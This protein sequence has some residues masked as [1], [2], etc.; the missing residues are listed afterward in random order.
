[1][2]ILE[3]IPGFGPTKARG[4]LELLASSITASLDN[5]DVLSARVKLPYRTAI[6][7]RSVVR[8]TSENGQITEWR[9]NN[10]TADEFGQAYAD[11]TG[12]PPIHD[13]T[14]AGIIREVQNGRVIT[15]FAGEHQLSTWL[16]TRLLSNIPAPLNQWLDPTLGTLDSDPV[17]QL[18]WSQWTYLQ[19]VRALQGTTFEIA[20][21]RQPSGLYRLCF[22]HTRGSTAPVT[23]VARGR[24]L[25]AR[26]SSS[27]DQDVASVIIP[28]G[29]APSEDWGPATIAENVWKVTA[30]AAGGWVSLADP[31][32]VS[33]GPIAIDDQF[34]GGSLGWVTGTTRYSAAIV[35]ARK[36]DGAV[37]LASTAN[38]SVGALTTIYADLVGNPLI[39]VTNPALV[40]SDVG[41]VEQAVTVSGG[42]GERNFITNPEMRTDASG[43]AM[44]DHGVTV[45]RAKMGQT[46]APLANGS[47]PAATATTTPLTVDGLTPNVDVLY[48]GDRID[49]NGVTMFVTTDAIPGPNGAIALALSTGLPGAL[50]DN[51]PLTFTRRR[52]RTFTVVGTQNILG[53]GVLVTG[54][55][56]QWASTQ[57]LPRDGNARGFV[58]KYAGLT[59]FGTAMNPLTAVSDGSG[60]R[61][62][63]QGANTN[64]FSMPA[65]SPLAGGSLNSVLTGTNGT[66]TIGGAFAMVWSV[67]AAQ[68]AIVA[69]MTV[70]TTY[71][72]ISGWAF[73][74][75]SKV[76]NGDGSFT[77]TWRFDTA[78]LLPGE[79]APTAAYQVTGYYSNWTYTWSNAQYSNGSTLEV[80]EE[81]ETRTLL[82]DGA[83]ASGATSLS[84][85]PVTELARRDFTTV[86]TIS[87]QRSV[88]ATMR[89][90][91]CSV[92]TVTEYGPSGEVYTVYRHT[93][94]LDLANSNV[95]NLPTGDW[96]DQSFVFSNASGGN[97]AIVLR[98]LSGSTMVVDVSFDL[99]ATA[100]LLAALPVTVSATNNTT[101]TYPVGS[102]AS[103]GSNG[104]AT[105]SITVPSGRSYAAGAVVTASFL[106]ASSDGGNYIH[107]VNAVTGP[108]SSV[109]L[110]G[111]DGIF[112]EGNV[113]SFGT[114][115]TNNVAIYRV[116]GSAATDYQSNIP[117]QGDVLYVAQTVVANGSGQA[118]VTL[119]AP[120]TVAIADNQVLT[121]VRNPIAYAGE[122]TTGNAVRLLGADWRTGANPWTKLPPC[123]IPFMPG[124]T[125]RQLTAEV[126]FVVNFDNG[127]QALAN[128]LQVGILDAA[129]N[130]LS[131][132]TVSQVYGTGVAQLIKIATQCT[133][134]SAGIYR[135]GVQ[136]GAYLN[137][138]VFAVVRSMLAAG[139]STDV[140]YIDGSWANALLRAGNTQLLARQKEKRA[141]TASLAEF[142]DATG[143]VPAAAALTPGASFEFQDE[144]ETLR[145]F[146]FTRDEFSQRVLSLNLESLQR[147]VARLLGAGSAAPTTGSGSAVL[148]SG[149]GGTSGGGT[150]GSTTVGLTVIDETG[151]A[152]S[153]VRTLD[154][155][156]LTLAANGTNRASLTVTPEPDVTSADAVIS[157]GDWVSRDLSVNSYAITVTGGTGS[158][159]GR[160][161]RW[162]QTTVTC[163]A[164]NG[165][166]Y[167]DA[168][169][170]VRA[171]AAGAPE[172]LPSGDELLLHRT[173][174]DTAIYGPRIYAVVDSRT[175]GRLTPRAPLYLRQRVEAAKITSGAW[176]GATAVNDI[177]DINWYFGNLGLYPFVE[178]LPAQVQDHLDVQIAKFFGSGGTGSADWNA[179]HGTTWASNFLRYPYDVGTPRGTPTKK[180]ADSHDAYIGTFLRLAVRYAKT[181]SGGLA[182]WDANY[183]D[184]KEA[185]YRNIVQSQRSVN[186]GAGYMVE[187]FQDPTVYPFCQTLDCIEAYRGLQDAL[188]LMA[189]RGGGQ[190]TDAA[191]YQA[192][193]TNMLNGVRSQ[194]SSSANANGET[195]W[196]SIAW[197]NAG[198]AKL[199]NN[200]TR[201]YPDLTMGVPAVLYGVDLHG[202]ASIAR[203]RLAKLFERL[204]GKAPGW[205]YSRRYDLYPWGIVAAAATK[206]GYRDIGEAWLSYVQRHH[207]NDAVGYLLIHDLGWA[208]YIERLLGG[209]VL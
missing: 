89:V 29:D 110:E 196:I 191:Y 115:Q 188:D 166:V 82:L 167:V 77:L 155:R 19:F 61:R 24:N 7:M 85:K 47:R 12:A 168:T 4:P 104:R 86:D 98:P 92:S 67:S 146:A 48:E 45:A 154:V 141:I 1:M 113:N 59:A 200:H 151:A 152:L 180:R 76:T 184:I 78:Q 106:P 114:P 209:E 101:D 21:E 108:A 112:Y 178:E 43:Y 70:N 160:T 207:A 91:A 135:I 62:I 119:K 107:L 137:R 38:L 132:A 198:A 95:D 205:F 164:A 44:G 203:D 11:I 145:L 138:E 88:T 80:W 72:N 94:T 174:V 66:T 22:Y 103:W 158:L 49:V 90:T 144:R 124:M 87:L 109:L 120:N 26:N 10:I 34:I 50:P 28:F 33:A 206:V 128:P 56:D 194:W 148:V 14:T 179:L 60:N 35:D 93:L 23:R 41:R 176:A 2:P 30:I 187:T 18:D 111:G 52:K 170:Q 173:Y 165:L 195:E 102:A 139:P 169:G 163:P 121:V 129:G 149:T 175:W 134:T 69:A 177:G 204:N 53:R 140:P 74:L 55:D 126:W 193:A 57:P 3:V 40:L 31:D 186:G 182:W 105:V 6:Q 8:H 156:G 37:Q 46:L 130:A 116:K 20:L 99:T 42:R 84:F 39:E 54:A 202:T 71:T 96:Q 27:D 201:W 36:S 161:I 153:D 25:L 123:Y 159:A 58:L 64:Q 75:D 150:G 81:R 118:A 192:W 197:D 5:N 147:T 122:S 83:H 97:A 199:V 51:Y 63:Y 181:A 73:I 68:S 125:S 162:S 183:N 15:A 190:A 143:V 127:N 157:G 100:Q 208:R 65:W 136:G 185:F 131:T 172:T 13:L 133:I 189:T 16:T 171:R 9:L 117:I 17:I 79:S 32:G 142:I